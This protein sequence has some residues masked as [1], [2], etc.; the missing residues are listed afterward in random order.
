[1]KILVIED[2]PKTS[3]YLAKGLEENGYR[4]NCAGN[5]E[6]GFHM[7][8]VGDYDLLILDVM[9]PG[10]DG[11]SILGDLRGSGHR[12]PILL[13]T[14]RDTVEDRVKGLETGADDYLVK[15][16]A[17]AELLARVRSLLRRSSPAEVL[18]KTLADLQ[19]DLEARRGRTGAA[20]R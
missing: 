6:D 5:G 19:V 11:W 9:L 1:M 16:F 2:E 20:A 3:A 12:F 7:A 15:P 14:A 17:F 18:K 4:V 13:L 10:K 8:R